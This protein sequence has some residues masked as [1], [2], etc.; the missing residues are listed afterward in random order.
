M[1]EQLTVKWLTEV[2]HRRP[3]ALLKKRGTQVLDAF[4]GH[5]TVKG[6]TVAS[7]LLIQI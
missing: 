2:L 6:K 3:G 4:K 1:M 5:L 7:D